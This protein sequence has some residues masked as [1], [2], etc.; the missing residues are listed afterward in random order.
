MSKYLEIKA[1]PKYVDMKGSFDV[2]TNCRAS[3]LYQCFCD[4][5]PKYGEMVPLTE[6]IL[7]KARENA[8]KAIKETHES[9]REERE[10]LE[11]LERVAGNARELATF[12]R[13]ME[14]VDVVRESIRD[15]E[16]DIERLEG[17]IV[18]IGVIEDQLDMNGNDW[19]F[20]V[21][22]ECTMP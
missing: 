13:I 19:S 2:A 4:I 18:E 21:G 7:N 15:Y 20:W 17:A 5:V 9:L 1:K 8:R 22:I 14:R 6:E 11:G 12:D 16:R 3:D 10:V